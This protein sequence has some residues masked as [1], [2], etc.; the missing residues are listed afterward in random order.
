MD[1]VGRGNGPDRLL[2]DGFLDLFRQREDRLGIAP[3]ENRDAAVDQPQV[4]V[5]RRR[6]MVNPRQLQFL[7]QAR[8]P[9]E[10]HA[11]EKAASRRPRVR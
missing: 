8:K 2:P 6:E 5:W 11:P 1:F 4:I 9:L 7:L 10:A 3:K